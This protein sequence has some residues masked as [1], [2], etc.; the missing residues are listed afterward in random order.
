MHYGMLYVM[1]YVMH[2]GMSCTMVC[3]ISC[4]MHYVMHFIQ[5]SAADV[6]A[7]VLAAEAA[8]EQGS[9]EVSYVSS[10]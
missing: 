10:T 6:E 8:D 7:M 5:A 3:S 9:L 1:H 2:Y 4:T